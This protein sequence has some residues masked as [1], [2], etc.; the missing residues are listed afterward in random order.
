MIVSART[1]ELR[2]VVTGVIYGARKNCGLRSKKRKGRRNSSWCDVQQFLSFVIYGVREGVS[3]VM[4]ERC[5]GMESRPNVALH[6]ENWHTR[7]Y[8]LREPMRRKQASC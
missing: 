6:L 1:E 8:I 4:W 7:V 5:P 2:E 3:K